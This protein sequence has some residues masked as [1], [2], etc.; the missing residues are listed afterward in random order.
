MH[1]DT[2]LTRK[3]PFFTPN[4]AASR[5]Y[6]LQFLYELAYAVLNSKTDGL[7]EYH[8]LMKVQAHGQSLFWRRDTQVCATMTETIFFIKRE[9]IP[10]ERKGNETH[11]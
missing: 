7:L 8:Y 6:P 1:G 2:R 3:A 5:Q 4:Q 11:A 9:E 10:D